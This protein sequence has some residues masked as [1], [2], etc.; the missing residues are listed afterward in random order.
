MEMER[1]LNYCLEKKG[2]T[3]TF[4]FGPNVSVIKVAS[5]MFALISIDEDIIKVNL[6]CDPIEADILR[7]QYSA[8]KPGYHMNK[9]HWI[10]RALS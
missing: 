10:L 3:E 2:T 9:L 8:V 1:L 5:K 7:I 6:K 4:P